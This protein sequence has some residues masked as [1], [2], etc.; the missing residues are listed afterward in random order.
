MILFLVSSC[1]VLGNYE[2]ERVSNNQMIY[3]LSNEKLENV[4]TVI[5]EQKKKISMNYERYDFLNSESISQDFIS[6]IY[7]YSISTNSIGELYIEFSKQRKLIVE[8]RTE[9]TYKDLSIV[10]LH[11]T[12]EDEYRDLLV[13]LT[14]CYLGD[15]V[16]E[17]KC[18]LSSDIKGKVDLEKSIEYYELADL[19]TALCRLIFQT[20]ED[21]RSCIDYMKALE[22]KDIHRILKETIYDFA[23]FLLNIKMLE[24]LIEATFCGKKYEMSMYNK[25]IV[26]PTEEIQVFLSSRV[27]SEDK[28]FLSEDRRSKLKKLKSQIQLSEDVNK[29]IDALCENAASTENHF[30]KYKDITDKRYNERNRDYLKRRNQAYKLHYEE[31]VEL[32]SE[33]S[34]LGTVRRYINILTDFYKLKIQM[35]YNKCQEDITKSSD[36]VLFLDELEPRFVCIEKIYRLIFKLEGFLTDFPEITSDDLFK[37]ELMKELSVKDIV[38]EINTMTFK[39]ERDRENKKKCLKEWLKILEENDDEDILIID[40]L[41]RGDSEVVSYVSKCGLP[42]KENEDKILGISRR[43]LVFVLVS[44]ALLSITILVYLYIKEKA[45][46]LG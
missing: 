43:L 16:E 30:K 35:K 18:V 2:D 46:R 15:Y 3:F 36:T 22:E 19:H 42:K 28:Y 12:V 6:R 24:K 4:K 38:N 44:C 1:L 20:E 11:E 26:C 14:S 8:C 7:L 5:D 10:V 29:R 33:E 25:Q 40:L 13:T 34:R 17:V 37:E 45:K 27:F 9:L 32:K 39:S 21:L 41:S 23:S 31:T